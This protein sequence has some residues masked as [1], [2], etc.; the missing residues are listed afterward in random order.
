MKE[1]AIP[2]LTTP[3]PITWG[4]PRI[5]SLVGV[6]GFGN[7]SSGPFAIYD[8]IFQA[9]DNFSWIKGKHSLRFGGEVRRD[10]YNQKGNEFA[11]GSFEFNGHLHEQSHR[12]AGRRF[13]GR[14]AD[15]QHDRGEAAMWLAFAQFRATSAYFY[16]DDTYRVN[17]KLTINLGLRYEFSPPWLDRSAE[18]GQRRY[19]PTY[20]PGCQ[21]AGSEPAPGAGA[22]RHGRLLRRQGL[23]VSGRAGGARWP[24]AATA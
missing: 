16:V 5:T 10:R 4:I 14:S 19:A 18:H 17:P 22:H 1:L 2:G 23:P 7:D 21:R 6:S 12:P 11:R 15:G 9:T 8:A 20:H 3:D 13:D 24:A